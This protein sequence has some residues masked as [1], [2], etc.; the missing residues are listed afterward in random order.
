MTQHLDALETYLRDAP[1]LYAFAPQVHGGGGHGGKFAAVLDGGVAV[2]CKPASGVG[3]A[4]RAA[5]NEVAAWIVARQLGWTEMMAATILRSLRSPAGGN[6]EEM[7]LQILWPGSDFTPDPSGFTDEEIWKAALFDYLIFH[8]DRTNN[9]WLGV[10]P[11]ALPFPGP[12]AGHRQQLK[13]IDHGYAFNYPGRDY[14]SSSFVERRR[15]ATIPD[16][17]R[18]SVRSL[19]GSAAGAL[20]GLLDQ[21]E[22]ESL[23]TRVNE[24]DSSGVLR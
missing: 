2:F 4:G 1:L 6:E 21:S 24:I 8:S 17:L 10:P 16:E 23:V 7:A 18:G 11:A 19:A 13:L 22:I 3:D 12:V 15:G 9:N 14:L 20:S 5:R